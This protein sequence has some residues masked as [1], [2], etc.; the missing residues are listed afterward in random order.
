VSELTIALLQHEIETAF[1][2]NPQQ[3]VQRLKARINGYL[4]AKKKQGK[5]LTSSERA[6]ITGF[7]AAI[8]LI[9]NAN[10]PTTE[11]TQ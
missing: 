5:Q 9:E 6:F 2:N 11:I 7:N 4:K 10:Q 1:K 3:Q 8:K